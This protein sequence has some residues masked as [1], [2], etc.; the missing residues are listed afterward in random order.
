[1]FVCL[2]AELK[3]KLQSEMEKNAQM[4]EVHRMGRCHSM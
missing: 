3:E 2:A 4:I 1:M